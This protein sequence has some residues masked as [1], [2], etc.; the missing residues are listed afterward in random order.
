MRRRADRISD[1]DGLEQSREVG[2]RGARGGDRDGVVA[3][4]H[5]Q[6]DRDVVSGASASEVKWARRYH[7]RD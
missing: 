3:H 7:S 4:G 5:D 6:E 2:Q 1:A